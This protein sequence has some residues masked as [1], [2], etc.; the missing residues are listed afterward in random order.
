MPYRIALILPN[1]VPM[2]FHGLRL[3]RPIFP[4]L[5]LMTLAAHTPPGFEL[6]LID[7]AVTDINYDLP[8]DMVAISANTALAPRAYE[9]ASEFRRRGAKV[10]MGGIHATALPEEAARYVDSVGIGEGEGY[11]AQLCQ[12]AASDKLQPLYQCAE[13]P[14]L[15]DLPIPRRDLIDPRHYTLPRTIQTSRG[16]P[17]RCSFCSVHKFFGGRYRMRP[18]GQVIEEIKTMP[19]DDN[20]PLIFVDDNIFGDKARS[21]ELLDALRPLADNWLGQA[22]MV[23]LQDEDFLERA[24]R[25]GCRMVFVGI[26]S[27]S[28]ANLQDINKQFN[29]PA[30]VKATIERCH[31]RGIGVFG[32]FIVGLDH[33]DVSVFDRIVDFALD[34]RIDVVQIAIRIPIPG[35]DDCQA[36]APRIFDHDYR[37]RDG[38]RAV[39]FHDR[40]HPPILLEQKLQW[41]YATLYSKRG[42]R[43]RLSGHDGP[44][45]RWSRLVNRGTALRMNKWLQRLALTRGI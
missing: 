28:D 27:L 25:S 31:R 9:V 42:M 6:Q 26:E 37:K 41:A 13:L 22:S 34:A 10:V 18:V 38:S 14:D 35:T 8:V 39:F 17:F 43:Q 20:N 33:D 30:E 40:I 15:S 44:H 16:C 36:L 3:A 1:P 5:S 4:P 21:I 29:K 45:L 23:S 24:A 2:R 11:W 19:G 32:A 7:E 12:D